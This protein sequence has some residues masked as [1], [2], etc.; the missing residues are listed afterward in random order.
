MGKT[1]NY[2]SST[3]RPNYTSGDNTCQTPKVTKIFLYSKK[4]KR[5]GSKSQAY[6]ETGI[7][8]KC[9]LASARHHGWSLAGVR[10]Y[11][12]IFDAVQAECVSL[13]GTEFEEAFLQYS[14]NYKMTVTEN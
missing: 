8:M 7:D 13:L 14:K 1:G 2:Q 4:P 6:E 10:T 9:D 5:G 12:L 3:V 11:N